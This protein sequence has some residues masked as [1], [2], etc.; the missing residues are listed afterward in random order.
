[1]SNEIL[2]AF[3]QEF[4]EAT[5]DDVLDEW[6]KIINGDMKAPELIEWG[7]ELRQFNLPKEMLEKIIYRVVDSCLFAFLNFIEQN[8]I[9]IM[10]DSENIRELSDGLAG[11]LYSTQ[12]WI[13]RF[14]KFPSDEG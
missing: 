7:N 13:N 11:E 5:R 2:N 6:R 12:G 1:M 8:D 10:W 9:D 4:I 14:S 3:G